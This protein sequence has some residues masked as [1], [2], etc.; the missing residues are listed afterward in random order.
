M[1]YLSTFR[2][3]QEKNSIDRQTECCRMTA[4]ESH[5]FRLVQREGKTGLLDSGSRPKHPEIKSLFLYSGDAVRKRGAE[6]RRRHAV[7]VP[8][9]CRASILVLNARVLTSAAAKDL[10]LCTKTSTVPQCQCQCAIALRVISISYSSKHPSLTQEWPP[11]SASM[12]DRQSLLAEVPVRP[13]F[14]PK[15]LPRRPAALPPPAARTPFL[16]MDATQAA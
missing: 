11:L 6:M 5:R 13:P 14:H 1:I 2:S 16:P 15:A 12:A 10:R 3:Q 9:K 8:P 7:R 4:F